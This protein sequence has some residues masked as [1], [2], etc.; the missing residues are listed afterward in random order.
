M[1]ADLERLLNIADGQMTVCELVDRYLKTKT[2][3]REGTKGGYVTVHRVLAKEN[4][5]SEDI[6]CEVISDKAATGRWKKF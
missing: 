4:Q 3:V 2:G 5:N 1:N 6:R